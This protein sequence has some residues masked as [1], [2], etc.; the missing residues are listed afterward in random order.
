[1]RKINFEVVIADSFHLEFNGKWPVPDGKSETL[2]VDIEFEPSTGDAMKDAE[3]AL[4]EYMKKNYPNK[5]YRIYY[6]WWR[7]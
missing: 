2:S 1:M 6:W 4:D 5:D 3:N 7:N